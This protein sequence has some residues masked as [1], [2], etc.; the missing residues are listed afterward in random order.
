M[1]RVAMQRSLSRR[2]V[3]LKAFPSDAKCPINT[4]KESPSVST[5]PSTA[6]LSMR[7][8]QQRAPTSPNSGRAQNKEPTTGA[9]PAINDQTPIRHFSNQ[10]TK[11]NRVSM[12]SIPDW[13]KSIRFQRRRSRQPRWV[14]LILEEEDGRI[15][16]IPPT[17]RMTESCREGTPSCRSV[18][19]VRQGVL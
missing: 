3:R 15:E 4:T 17:I 16:R 2:I 1:S 9:I 10:Y 13:S 6:A 19:L 12:K 11:M 18:K 5:A 14:S 8:G 7:V